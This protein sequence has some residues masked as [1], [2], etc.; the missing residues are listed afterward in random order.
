[1]EFDLAPA[2]TLQT[3]TFNAVVL[4]PGM[5]ITAL[6]TRPEL[7]RYMFLHIC[8]NFSRIL[9]RLHRTT[10]NFEVQRAFTVFQL[11]TILNES[12]HT[13]VLVEHDPTLYDVPERGMIM[14]Q[15]VRALKTA[16]QDAMVILYAPEADR[17]F[18]TLAKQADRV[19]HVTPPQVPSP[20]TGSY[21][22]CERERGGVLP[23]RQKQVTLEVFYGTNT[24]KQ[25]DRG[26]NPLGTVGA[27]NAGF[28]QR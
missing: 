18:H 4:P 8:G 10:S 14:G 16:A 13:I 27:G 20:G 15:V 21:R 6:D 2:V 26:E 7:Q 25:Q 28:A 12:Y 22:K 24:G 5:L 19:F 17:T 11:L 23:G 1:M 9:S 3:G